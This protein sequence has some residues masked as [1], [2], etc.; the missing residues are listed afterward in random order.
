[1]NKDDELTGD[2]KFSDDPEEDL[3][4]QNAFL[5]MKMMAESGASFGG[6][7]NLPS[8]IENQFLKNVIEFEK[9]FA[10]AKTQKI[11][12]ILG[13]PFFENE[14]NLNDEKFKIEFERLEGLLKEHDF[15]VDF[16]AE[17]SNRFKYNFITSELFDHETDFVAVKGMINNFI[18][19]E[20]YPDHKQEISDITHD[21]LNDFFDRKLNED[22]HYIND[23]LIL[24]DGNVLTKEQ[25]I[26]RFHS[27]YDVASQFENTL[28][29]IDNIDFELKESDE[30]HSGMG[31]SEG[32]IQYDMIFSGGERKKIKGPFKIYF[33]RE[34]DFWGI[35][36]F[37][38]AG[39][40]LQPKTS[41]S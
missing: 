35:C 9:A 27:M 26:N 7:G 40:N 21:F 32:E 2:E 23:E 36:F 13:K 18:Y 39:Y 29:K 8:D 37:Y 5:K 6:D 10:N 16:L 17:R 33:A 11:F 41:D 20:F 4:L 15:N 19:E 28:F 3:R 12:E 24:P 14:Q 34:W 22:T 25:L 31:F 30:Q 1:M 38:L